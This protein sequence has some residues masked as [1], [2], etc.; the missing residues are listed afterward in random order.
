MQFYRPGF[1]PILFLAFFAFTLSLLYS[2]EKDDRSVYTEQEKTSR[3]NQATDTNRKPH[4]KQENCGVIASPIGSGG[5][6][7]GNVMFIYASLYG[8]SKK[9]KRVPLLIDNKNPFAPSAVFSNLS[10]TFVTVSNGDKLFYHQFVAKRYPY[11]CCLFDESLLTIPCDSNKIIVHN[12]LQ[13]WRYFEEFFDDIREEF[14]FR[15]DVLEN[16]TLALK[17]ER[18][19]TMVND[20]ELWLVGEDCNFPC[21]SLTF[22]ASLCTIYRFNVVDCF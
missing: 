6:R 11:R 19:K 13:S 22:A 15:A 10:V 4:S 2:W 18:K 12:L 7:L 9:L 5:I 14:T 3:R 21:F 1:T 17:N 8:L 20:E 16:C